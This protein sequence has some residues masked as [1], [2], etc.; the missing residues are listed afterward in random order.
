[1]YHYGWLLVGYLH[2]L[3]VAS[4]I[5]KSS[6]DG[7]LALHLSLY[8]WELQLVIRAEIPCLVPDVLDRV[9]SSHLASHIGV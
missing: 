7:C 4:V 9:F 2:F 8:S 1:M 3:E 6:S 5:M